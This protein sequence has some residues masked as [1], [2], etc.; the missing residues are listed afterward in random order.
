MKRFCIVVFA[1]LLSTLMTLAI[2]ENSAGIGAHLAKDKKKVF[3]IKVLPNTPAQKAGLVE[4][5]EILEINGQKLKKLSIDEVKS[6][7]KGEVDTN[8]MLLVKVGRKKMEYNLTRQ[9]YK[10]PQVITDKNFAVHW[11]QVVPAQYENVTYIQPYSNYSNALLWSIEKNN[12]WVERREL[13]KTGYD[14][15]LTYPTKDRN[16]CYMNLVNREIDRT[17]KEKE[18]QNQQEMIRQQ[19]YQ[20]MQIQNLYHY[21]HPYYWY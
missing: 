1:F 8:I 6:I 7:I 13:F 5:S 15:C 4:G 2:E 21:R 10:I 18:L 16:A 9:I 11:R 19:M 20:N 17:L 12:Y 3:I 14:A